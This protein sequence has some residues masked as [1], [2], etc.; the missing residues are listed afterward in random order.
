VSFVVGTESM[1]MPGPSEFQRL[2]S[3]VPRSIRFALPA[4][5]VIC[6][7]LPMTGLSN[8]H[9]TT[10]SYG[11]PLPFL[12]FYD[13]GGWALWF[14]VWR[15]RIA[16]D[17]VFWCALL[18]GP[19]LVPKQANYNPKWRKGCLYLSSSGINGRLR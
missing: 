2:A 1:R 18:G 14:R 12:D 3:E 16:M 5:V 11:Q 4:M 8:M 17:I 19:A 13:S 7:A 10:W 6:T 15:F 9:G